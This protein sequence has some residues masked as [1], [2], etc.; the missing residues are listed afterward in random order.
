MKSFSFSFSYAFFCL[1]FSFIYF[2]ISLNQYFMMSYYT[3]LWERMFQ[4][5]LVPTACI[6]GDCNQTW[7]GSGTSGY[8][9]FGIFKRLGQTRGLENMEQLWP[10]LSGVI[11]RLLCP[12]NSVIK[13]Q[14]NYI[15]DQ[16]T[17]WLVF[18]FYFTSCYNSRMH[19]RNLECRNKTVWMFNRDQN[20]RGN[21]FT[22][23]D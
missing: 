8:A 5:S 15:D 19:Y 20:L 3:K 14:A 10:V 18:A 23:N 13:I 7:P 4:K 21:S 9:G 16:G 1:F 11:R 22:R 2:W 6:S 12:K 17:F